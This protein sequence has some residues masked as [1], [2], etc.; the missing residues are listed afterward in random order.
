MD[1]T[2]KYILLGIVGVSCFS[3][4]LYVNST[5][6]QGPNSPFIPSEGDRAVKQY[7]VENIT[8]FI[9]YSGEQTNE[10]YE[11]ISL[12]NFQTTVYHLLLN[13]CE[14]S[15]QNYGGYIYVNEINGV[16]TGWIYTI[17]NDAPPGIPSDYYNLL[18]N[19]TVRWTHVR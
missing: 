1:K 18:D 16:G 4:L 10:L 2:K 11:N 8:L 15:V 13:C 6:F 17:N 12:T 9:D 7:S 19:D 3:L 5:L 14:V